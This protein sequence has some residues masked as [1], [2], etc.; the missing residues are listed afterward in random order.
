MISENKKI[1][2]NKVYQDKCNFYGYDF[3]LHKD[4]SKQ[5]VLFIFHSSSSVRR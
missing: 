4:K 3:L 1:L 2:Q 5:S